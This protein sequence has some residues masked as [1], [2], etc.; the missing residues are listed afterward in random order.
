MPI[1][2][3]LSIW[4][5][6]SVGHEPTPQAYFERGAL[7]YNALTPDFNVNAQLQCAERVVAIASTVLGWEVHDI[8][9]ATRSRLARP[10]GLWPAA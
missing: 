9:S 4:V 6:L 8:E 5:L 3:L 10:A 1:Y 7:F 2:F